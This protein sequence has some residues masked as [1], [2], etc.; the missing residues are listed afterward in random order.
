MIECEI[1]DMNPQIFGSVMDGL[2]AAGALEVFYVPV[3]MKKNRPGTLLTVIATAVAP[4]A[5]DGLDFS[6]NHDHRPA[7]L[8]RGSSSVCSANW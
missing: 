4:I 6:R 3:Q 2:Y 7:A 1:D 5:D 8:R